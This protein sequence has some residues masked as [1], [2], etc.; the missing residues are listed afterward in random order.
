MMRG[1]GSNNIDH[2]LGQVDFSGQDNVPA[3]PYLGQAIADLEAVNA[4]LVVGSNTR[5]EQPLIATRL[6]KATRNGASVSFINPAE[7]DQRMTDSNSIAVAPQQMA[8]NLAAI[9][10]AA[11]E[12]RKA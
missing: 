5:L 11:A 12:K 2:R 6:R 3:F 8:A 7:L 9:A 10:K 4:V 1:I